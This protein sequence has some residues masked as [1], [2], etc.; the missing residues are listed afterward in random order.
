MS[1]RPKLCDV[2]LMYTTWFGWLGRGVFREALLGCIELK[3]SIGD[4]IRNNTKTYIFRPQQDENL[5]MKFGTIHMQQQ[6]EKLYISSC[7]C[8]TEFVQ[9]GKI[10]W[11]PF[12]SVQLLSFWVLLSFLNKNPMHQ[13]TNTLGCHDD[14]IF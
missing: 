9:C 1:G 4:E 12:P 6:D 7:C 11:R 2:Y 3:V 8:K 10:L 5:Y 14:H 13:S